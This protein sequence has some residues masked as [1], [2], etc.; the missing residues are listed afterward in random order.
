MVTNTDKTSLYFN[1]IKASAFSSGKNSS[2]A[3]AVRG[4]I[5]YDHNIRSALFFNVFNDY[6]YDK[7]QNLD[8]RFVLGGGLGFH[9]FKTETSSLDILAGVD[10][11]HSS[12]STPATTKT[13]EGYFGD[14]YNRKLGKAASFNQTARMFNDLNHLGSYRV[15]FDAG[16]SVRLTKWLN[17][18]VSLSDR[19]V[20]P[21]AIGRKSNDI[22]YTTGLGFTFAR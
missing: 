8:L 13:A 15:N 20:T 11:N 2:T 17:W 6:E 16:T 3:Q 12:Y 14:D 22:L 10:F 7:F 9:A 19:Y 1:T 18:N 21:P 4:G 5:A